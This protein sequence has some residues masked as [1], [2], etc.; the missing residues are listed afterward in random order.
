MDF[1]VKVVPQDPEVIEGP[2][3]LVVTKVLEDLKVIL[4]VDDMVIVPRMQDLAIGVRP[5]DL[6]VAVTDI[7]PP[8]PQGL[9][10]DAGLSVITLI[11]NVPLGGHRVV[12]PVAGGKVDYASSN[13]PTDG[14][15]ILGITTGA[16]AEDALV[17]VQTGGPMEEPTWLWIVGMP[18]YCGLNGVLTQSPP[19][20]G[21]L[22]RVGKAVT[23]TKIL[24]NVEEAIVLAG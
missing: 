12:K 2:E 19:N 1:I 14:D 21:V 6:T 11:A 4:P 24:V 16:V 18:V 22:C 13:V 7:G 10:G 20:V 5:S 3:D 15:Q 23:P 17:D 8:G 9:P